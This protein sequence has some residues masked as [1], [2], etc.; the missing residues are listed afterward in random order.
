MAIDDEHIPVPYT[1]RVR[2]GDWLDDYDVDE[3]YPSAPDMISVFAVEEN[4]PTLWGTREF[5]ET[6][7]SLGMRDEETIVQTLAVMD[8]AET[9]AKLPGASWDQVCV[10]VLDS[11]AQGG[12]PLHSQTNGYTLARRTVWTWRR[13]IVR[14]KLHELWRNVKEYWYLFRHKRYYIK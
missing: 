2:L 1:Q 8:Y 5:Y 10:L 3:V 11:L 14:L 13:T 7:I 9:L 4:F 6:A 12:I